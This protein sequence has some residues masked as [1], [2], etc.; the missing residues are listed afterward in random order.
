MQTLNQWNTYHQTT[1]VEGKD[2]EVSKKRKYQQKKKVASY[3]I[4]N[5]A[6][7]KGNKQSI[8]CQNLQRLLVRI[9]PRC[10][11]RS[12]GWVNTDV[13]CLYISI[14]PLSKVVHGYPQH[15]LQSPGGRTDAPVV[16]WWSCLKSERAARPKKPSHRVLIRKK[17]EE[18]LA[19]HNSNCSTY[20]AL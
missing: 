8:Q 2:K 20:S 11:H 16:S 18:Q 9:S 15:L 7:N 14:N 3:R 5:K 19:V 17:T 1:I 13:S 4:Q 12:P 10:P 6:S